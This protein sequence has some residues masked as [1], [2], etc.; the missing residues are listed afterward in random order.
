[1]RHDLQCGIL[2]S[3]CDTNRPVLVLIKIPKRSKLTGILCKIAKQIT[4]LNHIEKKFRFSSDFKDNNSTYIIWDLLWRISKNLRIEHGSFCT[5]SNRINHIIVGIHREFLCVCD[6][7]IG[8]GIQ[9][10]CENFQYSIFGMFLPCYS[11]HL[12]SE[13]GNEICFTRFTC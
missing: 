10:V 12:K 8:F 13:N 7:F 11:R 9:P 1:M 3:S 6:K 2:C 4:V 5:S